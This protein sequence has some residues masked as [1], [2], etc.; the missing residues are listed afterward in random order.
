[1]RR[2]VRVPSTL[3]G[4]TKAVTLAG[5]AAALLG[6]GTASAATI[7][8][9]TAHATP[10]RA[11]SAA[12]AGAVRHAPRVRRAATETAPAHR[13][14]A[15]AATVAAKPAGKSHAS[16]AGSLHTWAHAQAVAASRTSKSEPKAA[17]QLMPVGTA[18][19][20][21]Y[22]QL[23]PSQ[24]E[25]VKTI[26]QQAMAKKMG[27]RSAVIAV[28]TSMQESMLTNINYGDR[29]SLG[30]FQQRPSAGWGSPQQILNPKF[31]AD[32]FLSALQKYQSNDPSWVRQPLW[33]NAQAVQASGFPL[34]YAKWEA[35]AAHLV[36][37]VVTQQQ[38]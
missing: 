3:R 29:D 20:Q 37:Q 38:R 33:A 31:A 8:P 6:A 2:T 25:N 5:A 36:K 32:A 24:L 11:T 16:P 19:A 27:V 26:V 34:A 12:R 15:H 4:K 10:A 13:T 35:Q 1:M 30:L 21:S 23:T 14:V 9:A 22:M 7:I 28:A 17:D 18:G